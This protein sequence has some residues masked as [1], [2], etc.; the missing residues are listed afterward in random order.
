MG[1][2]AMWN[3]GSPDPLYWMKETSTPQNYNKAKNGIVWS[4]RTLSKTWYIM[5]SANRILF[6]MYGLHLQ[7]TGI[8]LNFKIIL[9]SIVKANRCDHWD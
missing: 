9:L 7:N 5:S 8:T 1:L 3:A 6:P 4:A 2:V